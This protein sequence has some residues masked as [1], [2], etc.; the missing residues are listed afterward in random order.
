MSTL[1]FR[2]S[3]DVSSNKAQDPWGDLLRTVRNWIA[4]RANPTEE[5]SFRGAWFFRGGEWKSAR[6]P[7]IHV[8]TRACYGDGTEQNSNCWAVEYEHPCD[9]F[10]TCR[11]WRTHVGVEQVA[12]NRFHFNLQTLYDIR[13]GFIGPLPKEPVPS[14]PG[15]VTTLLTSVYWECTAGSE[16][17]SPTPRVLHVGH[18]NLFAALLASKERACPVVLVSHSYP[19]LGCVLDPGKLARLLGGTAVVFES[20]NSEVDQ[21]LEYVLGRRFSCWNGMIRIYAPGVDFD[22]NGDERRHR[23]ILKSHV[24]AWG[25]EQTI[26]IIVRG[27]ARRGTRL[28]GILTPLDVESMTRRRRL[29]QLR[30]EQSATTKDE[31]LRVLEEDNE[32]MSSANAKLQEEILSLQQD[33]EERDDCIRRLEFEKRS[34]TSSRLQASEHS[35]SSASSIADVLR[36]LPKTLSQVISMIQEVHSERIAFT[37]QAV[38]SANESGFRDIHAAWK[39][40]A[41]MATTLHDLYYARDGCNPEKEFRDRTGFPLALTEGKQTNRNR[42]LRD[43]RRDTFMGQEVDITPH[44]KFDDDTTRAYFAPFAQNGTKL[45]V[46]GYIG[47]LDT[48]GTRRRKN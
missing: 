20:E 24:E 30:A 21:E 43:R 1:H 36:E 3:F 16:K 47:H 39:A 37:E 31:W 2:C 34:I 44:V 35:S 29:A 38:R 48:D 14:P 32:A 42:K 46:V 27:L 26:E 18:G 45:I 11:T 8:R 10:P 22:R 19:N 9:D 13:P 25:I 23:F 4:R 33:L 17:L 15:P 7:G 41:A 12:A 40:L 28:P 5:D 6:V